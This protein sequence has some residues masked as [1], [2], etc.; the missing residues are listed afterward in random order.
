MA[1]S[2]PTRPYTPFDTWLVQ[3]EKLS[4]SESLSEPTGSSPGLLDEGDG[5]SPPITAKPGTG[6]EP[7]P[8]WAPWLS[9]LRERE[10]PPMDGAS[11]TIS[12]CR[13]EERRVSARGTLP[14]NATLTRTER[15]HMTTTHTTPCCSTPAA[16]SSDRSLQEKT[17]ACFYGSSNSESHDSQG[18]R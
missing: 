12:F 4:D 13:N 15:P 11:M 10:F 5:S 3:E 14:E 17:S 6:N 18:A 9:L 2:D 8:H 7:P 16:H 1:G